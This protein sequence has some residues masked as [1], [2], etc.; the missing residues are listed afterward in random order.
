MELQIISIVVRNQPGVL[1]R[2]AGMFLRRGFNIDSLAVGTT[3]NLA[4]SRMTVTMQADEGTIKQVCK[5]LGK[6]VEVEAV[7]V[8]PPRSVTRS[9]VMVKVHAGDNRLEL[10]RLGD[11]FRAHAVDVTGDSLIFVVTGDA[12]KLKAFVD[13]MKPYGILEMVQTGLVALER[14]NTAL[15][16]KKSRYA[17]PEDSAGTSAI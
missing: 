9:M 16:V 10:L 2:V 5:Q 8:L 1:M 12:G 11:V 6:L 13:V 3:Q 4:F 15:D 7:K 17:W 14:G